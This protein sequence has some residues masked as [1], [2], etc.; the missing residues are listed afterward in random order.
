M[1]AIMDRCG[2]GEH[3]FDF[4]P[5]LRPD[6]RRTAANRPHELIS[7]TWDAAKETRWK[8]LTLIPLG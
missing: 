8:R 3:F 1:Y 5:D 6:V 7:T 4:N 2:S